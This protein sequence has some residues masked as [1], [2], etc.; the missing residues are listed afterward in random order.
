MEEQQR[1]PGI[2]QGRCKRLRMTTG[3]V[4][5]LDI[6][7]Y[8]N[9]LLARW[10]LGVIFLR[11]GNFDIPLI[12][13]VESHWNV[14]KDIT[15]TIRYS[16]ASGRPYTPDNLTLSRSQDRD[17]YELSRVNSVRASPYSRLDFRMERSSIFYHRTMTWHIGLE[18]SWN[19]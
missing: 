6:N 11:K 19:I 16:A 2:A 7:P 8:L 10:Q 4:S 13:N 14:G 1:M 9:A 18:R 15:V 3:T 5:M 17:V 12:A